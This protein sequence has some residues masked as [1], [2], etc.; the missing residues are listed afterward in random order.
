MAVVQRSKKEASDSR[1]LKV[2]L[3]R[4]LDSVFD[5]LGSIVDVAGGNGTVAKIICEAFPKLKCTVLDLPVA[6]S[7]L[8]G[9]TNLSFVWW[10]HA[11]SIPHADAVLMKS[12][13]LD[14]DD[15]DCIKILKNAKEAISG[16]GN[17]GKVVIIDMVMI[18]KHDQNEM[19]ETKLLLNMI[20]NAE[21]NSKLRS[22][23]DWKQLFLKAGF[24][25]YKI[26]PIF[27]LSPYCPSS[28]DLLGIYNN[29]FYLS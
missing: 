15:D 5:G 28:L 11:Q 9:N 23:E 8:T 18:E 2:T 6:V 21:L 16:K 26:F 1:F 4:D 22:E 20:L 10:G 7:N 27:G 24:T 25:H 3:I 12:V 13:L 19:L 29:L 14:W 17:E